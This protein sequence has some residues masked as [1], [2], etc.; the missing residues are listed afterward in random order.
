MLFEKLKLTH[1]LGIPTEIA[2][3]TPEGIVVAKQTFGRM[4]P[5]KT[6]VSGLDPARFVPFPSR[7]L[8]ADRDHPRLAF[9]DGV[10][11]L[12]ADTHDRNIVV[13][14]DGPV[15]PLQR[16]NPLAPRLDVEAIA[17]HEKLVQSMGDKAIWNKYRQS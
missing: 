15:V 3:I 1:Q 13:A 7:F 10:P 11:W 6:D 8:R 14:E 12:I 17:A 2:G 4:L 5:E 16:T 9:L